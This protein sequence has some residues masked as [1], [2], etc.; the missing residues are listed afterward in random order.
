[1]AI[2][3]SVNINSQGIVYA[4]GTGTF[5][6]IDGSTSGKVLTSNGTGV[7]PSFQTLSANITGPGSSTDRAV[8]TWNG[9][10]GAALFNNSTVLID[11]TG[12][13]TNTAQPCF[14]AYNNA[15]LSNVTGN[16]VAYTVILNT[17]LVN[18]G[19]YYDTTTGIF[20]APVT[21]TY[22]FNFTFTLADLT[23]S[24][25]NMNVGFIVGANQYRH[26]QLNPYAASVSGVLSISGSTMYYMTATNTMKMVVT[27]VGGGQT[28]DL[29]GDG[30]TNPFNLFSGYLVC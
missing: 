3:N 19:S 9:T 12:R 1:M 29:Y 24:N 15:I 2:S 17:A 27:V 8:A 22:L 13:Q 7:A 11:S 23:S 4:N 30:S 20:T 21:G 26:C 6:G 16:S 5:S 14:S 25:T 10:T 28:I 18:Q